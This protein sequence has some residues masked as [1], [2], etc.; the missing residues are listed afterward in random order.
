MARSRFARQHQ[1]VTAVLGPILDDQLTCLHGFP[2]GERTRSAN[3]DHTGGRLRRNIRAGLTTALAPRNGCLRRPR[4]VANSE[5]R[6]VSVEGSRYFRPMHYYH[7]LRH[8]A[9][10]ALVGGLAA[11]DLVS[12]ALLRT[13]NGAV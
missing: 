5:L 8:P 6:Q 4:L 7:L 12:R 9:G 11:L 13:P 3:V 1:R 10:L 2:R